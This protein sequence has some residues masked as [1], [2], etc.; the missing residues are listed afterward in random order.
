MTRLRE[1]VDLKSFDRDRV[2]FPTV[3]GSLPD[4]HADLEL[5][6]SKARLASKMAQGVEEAAQ[7]VALA[8]SH[9]GRFCRAVRR[10]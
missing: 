8:R 9:R 1:D 2:G 10:Q 5:I 6:L 3:C 7:S 4:G